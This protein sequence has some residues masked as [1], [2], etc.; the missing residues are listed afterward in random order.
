MMDFNTARELADIRYRPEWNEPGTFFVSPEGWEDV[1]HFCVVVGSRE[2]IVNEDMDFF[3]MA[4]DRCVLVRKDT[5]AIE[6]VNPLDCFEKLNSMTPVS[7]DD[8]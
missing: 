8:H 3:P 1:E 5:G 6:E 7:K 2:W 4:D